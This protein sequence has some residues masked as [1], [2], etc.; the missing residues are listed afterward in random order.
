MKKIP[1]EIDLGFKDAIIEIGKIDNKYYAKTEEIDAKVEISKEDYNK[2]EMYWK[3]SKSI[4]LIINE[5]IP[6]PQNGIIR[7]SNYKI[8]LNVD[9]TE[10]LH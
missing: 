10:W 6:N 9:G 8:E 1:E 5:I 7:S 2:I 4:L 3:E